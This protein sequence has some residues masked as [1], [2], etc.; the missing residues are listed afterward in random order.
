MSAQ[1]KYPIGVLGA[2]G[3]V[4]QRFI[5]LLE[6][7]PWFEIAWLAASDRSSGKSY[8]EAAKWRLDTPLPEHIARMTVS[9]ADPQGAP[10]II[11][12]S[13]DAAHARELEPKFAN[14]GCA[15]VSNSSAFRMA[16]NVPLVIPEVNADHLHLIE[17]Q[18][19]R[20][21]SGG[22][23]VTNPNCSTIGL[24]MALKPIEERFGIEQIFVTTM[25]AVSG[26]GYPGV[27]SMDILG[28]VIPYIGSEEEKMEAETLKLLG[29]L[30]GHSVAPLPA[31][32]TAHCNRVAVEDGH[33]ESVS[34]RLGSKL[35]RPVTHEDILAAWSEFRPLAGQHLPTAPAQP[36][37]WAPQS[38][39]PQ[40]RLDRNRGN[41][42]SVT[43]GRLRPCGVLDW[44]FTVLSH[45]TIRGAAGAAILNAE[46]LASLGKLEPG[47]PE[48]GLRR[49]G[50]E[51]V[52]ATAARA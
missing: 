12:A 29:R 33:T 21:D 1:R 8:G 35:G 22:Y 28:N 31:R 9:P 25:Q 49:R 36:V 16:P 3:M 17:E 15:V 45:N 42:M 23:M 27:P 44:K 26:A 37:E 2:T 50:G 5:Q 40:P 30:H 10:R 38:D 24:V 6:H 7:H 34:I 14:A 20:R 13:V 41:G 11:F 51:P 47:S 18:P 32:I 43:V 4:G 52:A 19:A 39:R 48:T 46:L